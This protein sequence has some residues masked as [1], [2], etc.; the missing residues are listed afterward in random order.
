MKAIKFKHSNV[1]FAKD[2]PEG[3]VISC[4]KLSFKERIRVLIFGRIW[5][6]LLTFNKPLTPSLLSTNR[7]ELYSHPDDDKMFLKIRKA[8]ESAKKKGKT[9]TNLKN[10]L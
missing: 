10:R 9:E 1:E 4:W 5:M 2:Q 7:K 3:H 8:F 6:N